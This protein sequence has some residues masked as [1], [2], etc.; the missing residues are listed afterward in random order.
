MAA[1]PG[2]KE[3]PGEARMVFKYSSAGKL[4]EAASV[5]PSG[6]VMYKSTYSYD[7]R[8]RIVEVT[9]YDRDGQVTVRRVYSYSSDSRVPSTFTYYGRDGKVYEKTTY[10][11]YEFNSVGDWV[12]RK[13]TREQ[14]FNRKS[15]SII[16]R[17]IEYYPN[18]R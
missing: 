12:K 9:G 2:Y 1:P 7:E 15:T 14:T 11:D 17:E 10:S 16:S 4:V 6:K 18:K 3:E 13:E 5:K 8:G